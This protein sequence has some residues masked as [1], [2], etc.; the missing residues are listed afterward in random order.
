M[1]GKIITYDTA[2]GS[3]IVITKDN[4]K[5]TFSI[6]NWNSFDILPQIGLLITIGYNGDISPIDK[7]NNEVIKDKLSDLKIK[8]ERY[9]NGSIANGWKLINDNENGF[10]I[11]EKI[12]SVVKF[13]LWLFGLSI[14]LVPFFSIFGLVIALILMFA[15]SLPY[16]K[17][18]LVGVV[19]KVNCEINITKNEVFYKKLFI[20]NEVKENEVKETEFDLRIKELN[21]QFEKNLI[22]KEKFMAEK[23]K[24]IN[25]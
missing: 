5:V 21:E 16:N 14:I 15:L 8:K 3:G 25:S 9:I 23:M 24:L 20:E 22:S 18:T 19:D 1:D 7:I 13:F 2:T 6:N 4:K 10:I 12:F 17:T 11:E